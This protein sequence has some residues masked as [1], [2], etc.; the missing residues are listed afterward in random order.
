MLVTQR[1]G[2]AVYLGVV[3]ARLRLHPRRPRRRARVAHVADGR[4]PRQQGAVRGRERLRR[5]RQSARR[6]VAVARERLEGG[7]RQARVVQHAPRAGTHELGA[8][9]R[10]RQQAVRAEQQRILHARAFPCAE[11]KNLI[12]RRSSAPGSV[13]VFCCPAER[14]TASSAPG[15]GIAT[16]LRA[17]TAVRATAACPPY[18]LFYFRPRCAAPPTRRCAGPA[19]GA[20]PPDTPRP[21]H[22]APAPGRSASSPARPPGC[23]AAAQAPRRGAQCTPARA[24]AAVPVGAARR[25]ARGHAARARRRSAQGAPTPRRAARGSGWGREVARAARSATRL[26]P[27]PMLRQP[28]R[29]PALA[30]LAA[31]SAR[32]DVRC[33]APVHRSP[34][35]HC[36]PGLALQ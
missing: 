22:A 36:V 13:R 23:R 26:R 5:S 4:R 33:L 3:R 10:R 19:P 15:C 25:A 14:G 12:S 7:G 16:D 9:Q 20:P 11:R 21:P 32:P 17:Q 24:P 29:A 34:P 18:A 30:R 6:A 28:R 35:A 27:L 31:A 1:C 8:R 2:Q